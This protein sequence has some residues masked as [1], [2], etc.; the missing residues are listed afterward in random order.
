MANANPTPLDVCRKLL[1]TWKHAGPL[2]SHQMEKFNTVVRMA[3][4]AVDEEEQ[5]A[6]DKSSIQPKPV[7]L[8]ATTGR[9]IL[10]IVEAF[11]AEFGLAC[12]EPSGMSHTAY[13]QAVNE[14]R[15][16]IEDSVE[17]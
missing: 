5:K 12:I 4:M 17:S 14:L 10:A 16:A 7:A 13:C 9:V 15:E 2:G 8:D 3:E 1:N 6:G 11:Q